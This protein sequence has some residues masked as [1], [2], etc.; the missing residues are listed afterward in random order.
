MAVQE[1][2]SKIVVQRGFAPKLFY[3]IEIPSLS[4]DLNTKRLKILVSYVS[5]LYS[6]GEISERAFKSI[7]NHAYSSYLEVAVNS[8]IKMIE[9]RLQERLE[10]YFLE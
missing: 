6:K 10:Q 3:E 2:G 9:L 4:G 1:R 5:Y 8:K 7:I